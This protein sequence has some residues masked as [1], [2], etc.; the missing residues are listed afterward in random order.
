M[1]RSSRTLQTLIGAVPE[2]PRPRTV[3]LDRRPSR[4]VAF[5]KAIGAIPEEPAP[6]E[7]QR[8]FERAIGVSPIASRSP[9]QAKSEAEAK[10]QHAPGVRL[11]R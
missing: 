3:R 6:P 8:Y 11:G 5:Q 9:K 2:E 4:F 1:S 10:T 7:F